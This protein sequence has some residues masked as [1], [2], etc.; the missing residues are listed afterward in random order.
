[1]IRETAIISRGKQWTRV[2]QKSSNCCPEFFLILPKIHG[3][4][5]C[6]VS[7]FSCLL[8]WREV[9]S[10]TAHNKTSYRHA[11][12]GQKRDSCSVFSLR[13]CSGTPGPGNWT[14]IA[15]CQ[16]WENIF[17]KCLCGLSKVVASVILII[18]NIIT[19]LLASETPPA[20]Q[21]LL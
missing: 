3:R 9:S 14:W 16:I 17:L 10:I 2:S 18:G 11:L 6:R 12:L 1:M 20:F 7:H 15:L 4:A 21:I 5:H 8:N 13:Q 19:N